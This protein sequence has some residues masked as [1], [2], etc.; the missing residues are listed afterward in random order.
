MEFSRQEYL[1]WVVIPFLRL[2]SQ[3]R[4]PRSPALQADFSLSGLPGKPGGHLI[5]KSGTSINLLRAQGS[6][7]SY[8]KCPTS[9]HGSQASSCLLARTSPFRI[10]RWPVSPGL[11]VLTGIFLNRYFLKTLKVFPQKPPFHSSQ[12]PSSFLHFPKISTVA[13]SKIIS[14]HLKDIIQR[15]MHPCCCKW[16]YFILQKAFLNEFFYFRLLL[17]V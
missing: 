11:L 10:L 16:H 7:L 5:N 15:W 6:F 14:F 8:K 4:E 12:C 17:N 9:P 13:Q 2:S 3:P 1:E